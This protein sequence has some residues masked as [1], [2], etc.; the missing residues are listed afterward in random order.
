VHGFGQERAVVKL[1]LCAMLIV[2]SGMAQ[3]EEFTTKVIAVLDGD[4]VLIR[5]AKGVLKIR[6][7]DIDAP[8]KAQ[9]FG[10]S[11]QQSLSGM[12]LGKQ[13]KVVSQ[14][15][16]QYG[17]MVAHLSVNGLDVNTEQIRRGMAWEYS[18]Y[19]SNHELIALEA[20]A[21]Q[22]PRGLWA[23]SHPTPPWDWR[24]Q[25]P[26]TMPAAHGTSTTNDPSC[27]PKKR[28]AQMTSCEEARH[29]LTLCGWKYLDGDG[30]GT[31]CEKLCAPHVSKK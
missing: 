18:H 22:A 16:D 25:H 9:P 24:K 23:M 17:R 3:A 29:Y 1:L 11:S 21:R 20:E 31:P 10:A 4:T 15:M 28:C 14:A 27:Q 13:V 19:H 6:L 8:E 7:A 12:V 5:R 30:D 2:L 26:N